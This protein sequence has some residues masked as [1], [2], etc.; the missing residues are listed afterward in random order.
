MSRV[1]WGS[2]PNGKILPGVPHRWS[3]EGLVEV[4]S[5]FEGQDRRADYVDGRLTEGRDEALVS[6][7]EGTLQKCSDQLFRRSTALTSDFPKPA[8]ILDA[9]EARG[10]KSSG[11][12][13]ET[14]GCSYA[15]SSH[16][17]LVDLPGYVALQ[18]ADD[19]SF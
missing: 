1:G 5:T 9:E 19:L 16:Q 3:V 15:S 7:I 8:A 14:A 13:R 4:V 17:N 2:S 11:A 18:A 12:H 6:G 10:S